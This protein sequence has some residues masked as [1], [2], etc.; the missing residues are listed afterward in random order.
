MHEAVVGQADHFPTATGG[1]A[2]LA[3]AR[4]LSA[5]VPAEPLLGM[6][7]LTSDE[8][9]NPA[10]RIRVGGQIKFLNFASQALKDDFLGFDLALDAE[11]RELGLLYYVLSSS[12]NLKEALERAA[13]YSTIVNEGIVQ[14]LITREHQGLSVRYTGVSRHLDRHQI[15]FWMVGLVRICR[16]LTGLRIVPQCVRFMHFRPGDNPRF[17]SIFGDNVEF[18]ASADEIIFAT[19]LE[20]I[21]VIGADPYLNSLLVKYCDEAL[22]DRPGRA[23]SFRSRV[24]NAIVPLLPH[25]KA[26]MG[27]IAHR[28]GVSKRTL[29]R[30]LLAEDLGF[31]QLLDDLRLHLAKRY[32]ADGDLSISQ[33][34][35]LLGYQEIG[36]FSRAFKRWTGKTPRDTRSMTVS[37]SG[38]SS[39]SQ[40]P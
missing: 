9:R 40:A 29:A 1:I 12:D 7:G 33:I 3:Y 5:G 23:R 21:P 28:L 19:N 8:M 32:L 38:A 16:K 36:A 18:S 30:R 11:F 31:S 2:R 22:A 17:A 14:E 25:G 37:G 13:R 15:E 35:W 26:E 10:M 34:A 27:E 39:V 24:E 20:Q 4:L 6:A